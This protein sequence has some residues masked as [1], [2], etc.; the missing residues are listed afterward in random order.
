MPWRGHTIPRTVRLG[1]KNNI[2]I[3]AY[4]CFS[5]NALQ[6]SKEKKTM[7]TILEYLKQES[8]WRGIIAIATAFGIKLAPEQAESIIAAGL[9]AIGLINTFKKG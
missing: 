8:T 9:A 1:F 2:D 4:L 7:K 5:S 6:S 3:P